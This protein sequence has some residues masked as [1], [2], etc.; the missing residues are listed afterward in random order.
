M[1]VLLAVFFTPVFQSYKS[2]SAIQIVKLQEENTAIKEFETKQSKV[3][4]NNPIFIQ[5]QAEIKSLQE[6]LEMY[7]MKWLLG[8]LAVVV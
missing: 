4:E 8:A 1:T 5:N 3:A 2:E 6:P 7:R